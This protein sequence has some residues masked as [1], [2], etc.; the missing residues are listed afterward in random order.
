MVFKMV[1]DAYVKLKSILKDNIQKLYYLVLV[2]L[3]ETIKRNLK[4][5]KG[6]S[7]AST[8]FDVLKLINIT[9]SIVFKF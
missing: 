9:R 8:K 1:V 6:W 7:K 3:T 2:Q 5:S 4:H